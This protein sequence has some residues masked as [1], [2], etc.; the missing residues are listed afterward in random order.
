MGYQRERVGSI[1]SRKYQINLRLTEKEN[2]QVMAICEAK[3]ITKAKLMDAALA[4]YL[5]KFK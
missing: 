3:G 5:R 1:E 4:L 2:A